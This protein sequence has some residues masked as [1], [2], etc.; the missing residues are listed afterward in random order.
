MNRQ[1]YTYIDLRSMG[2]APFWNQIKRYPQIT[3]TA[4]LRKSLKGTEARD[5]VDGICK[6]GLNV[7][8]WEFRKL[9][10]AVLPHWTDDE[11]KFHETIVLAQYIRGQIAKWGDDPDIR[12]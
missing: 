4:D 11:T 5:K 3:V 6:Y 10:E 1:I 2:S 8:A 9:S 12:H 7:Q